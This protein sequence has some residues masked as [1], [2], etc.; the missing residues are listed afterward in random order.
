MTTVGLSS[1]VDALA[2]NWPWLKDL[3][4]SEGKLLLQ[5]T[6]EFDHELIGVRTVERQPVQVDRQGNE[7][8]IA[9]LQRGR[10]S[11]VELSAEPTNLLVWCF[12][13][14]SVGKGKLVP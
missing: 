9:R 1:M 4:H 14:G 3:V 5:G 10:S 2:R 13:V 8:F 6:V 11:H 12:G 7:L